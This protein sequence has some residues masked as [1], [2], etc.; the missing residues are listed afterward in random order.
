[1]TDNLSE[2][3]ELKRL[4]VLTTEELIKMRAAIADLNATINLARGGLHM[5]IVLGTITAAIATIAVGVWDAMR[6]H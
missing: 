6:H 4:Q 5:L 2:I 1:M 3:V